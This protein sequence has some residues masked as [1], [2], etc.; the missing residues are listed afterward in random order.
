VLL[1]LSANSPFWNGFDTGLASARA[2]IFE[3]LPN[4]GIPPRST[5]STP[6]SAT[7]AGWSS[8]ALSPTAANSGSTCAPTLATARSRCAPR[9]PSATP[10]SLAFVE[11]VHALVV[12]YAERYADGESPPTLRRE[13]LDENKWRAIRHG[14]DASFITRDGEDTVSLGEAVADEC[15][16]L[17]IDGIRDVYDAESGSQRQRR[18]RE[19]GGLDAL[20]DDLMLSP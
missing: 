8:G 5:T 16:R 4:T 2:K 1:A 3:N 18:L 11:Y 19:E 10:G 12:D 14:H 7:S 6:S 17:G 15:D 20:C 13:L 9:T